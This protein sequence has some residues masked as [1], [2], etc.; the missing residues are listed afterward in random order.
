[1]EKLKK[2]KVVIPY[3]ESSTPS[4]TFRIEYDIE[5]TDNASALHK[6]ENMF[7]SYFDSTSASWVRTINRGGIRVWRIVEN[8]PQTPVEIDELCQKL[9]NSSDDASLKEALKQLAMLEDART[10][11]YILKLTKHQDLEIAMIALEALEKIGD[12]TSLTAVRNLYKDNSPIE[13]K[14]R[15]ISAISRIALP[16]DDILDF[17]S[18]LLEDKSRSVQMAAEKAFDQLE[19]RAIASGWVD[20]LRARQ[21]RM[22]KKEE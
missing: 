11:S 20:W 14:V 4:K 5:A 16:E 12:P 7:N 8:L 22:F 18:E 13:L 1:M 10:T 19:A 17:M 3:S 21:K 9:I 15:I 6:G 2:Y